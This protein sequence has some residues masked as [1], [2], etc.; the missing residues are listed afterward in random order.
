MLNSIY[1]SKAEI[2]HYVI[3]NIDSSHWPSVANFEAYKHQVSNSRTRTHGPFLD[4]S[5]YSFSNYS[6]MV[7]ALGTGPNSTYPINSSWD[8]RSIFFHQ[9]SSGRMSEIV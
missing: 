5:S 2:C 1:Y 4:S 3:I 8:N 7:N 6:W 9:P